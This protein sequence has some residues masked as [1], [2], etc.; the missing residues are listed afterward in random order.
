MVF[1]TE[2]LR[3]VVVADP[4]RIAALLTD[5]DSESFARRERAVQELEGLGFAAEPALRQ[6]LREKPS[7]EVRWRVE[8]LLTKLDGPEALRTG[9]VIEALERMDAA[10]ARRLLEALARGVPE[11]R[12]TREAKASLQRL[13]G[14][15]A[16]AP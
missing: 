6:A 10:E 4:R 11:A 3:P 7:L 2:H 16:P 14:R 13:A 1:L 9:R 15:T 12:L 5:L 8:S